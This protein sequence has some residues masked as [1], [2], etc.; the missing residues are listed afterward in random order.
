[1]ED[2]VQ[3]ACSSPARQSRAVAMPQ[4]EDDGVDGSALLSVMQEIV[5]LVV[6]NVPEDT[7]AV[8]CHGGIPV[9]VE[10]CVR[11]LPE[12]GRENDEKGRRHDEPVLVHW[13]VV[14][15]AMKEKVSGDADTIVR[16]VPIHR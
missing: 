8:H 7:A 11:K 6:A 9:V 13:K 15:N 3:L 1:M 16:K 5:G 10:D 4:N 2:Y 12:G 14:M